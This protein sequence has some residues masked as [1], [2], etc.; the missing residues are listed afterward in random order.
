MKT[1][2]E[3]RLLILDMIEITCKFCFMI[4]ENT[5]IFFF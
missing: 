3:N 4:I 2:C 1:V 5:K